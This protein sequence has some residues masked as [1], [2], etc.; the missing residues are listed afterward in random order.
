MEGPEEA[1]VTR[2]SRTGQACAPM[3]DVA[4]LGRAPEKAHASHFKEV[5]D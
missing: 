3:L 5:K 2:A 4:E 1:W